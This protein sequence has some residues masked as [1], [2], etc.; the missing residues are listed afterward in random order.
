MVSINELVLKNSFDAEYIS[1]FT[2][3]IL[4]YQN[5]Q[6]LYRK[7]VP[8]KHLQERLQKCPL[9]SY[10]SKLTAQ[11]VIKMAATDF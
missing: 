6:L 8:R 5:L 9:A 1:K 7:S 3:Q 11:I 10:I 2:A 4:L